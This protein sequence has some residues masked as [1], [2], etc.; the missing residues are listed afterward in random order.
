MISLISLRRFNEE[1]K[2]LYIFKNDNIIIIK[3]TDKSFGVV[4]WN[5]ED[6]LKEEHKQLSNKEV[7]E[8]VADDPST[9][10]STIFTALNK[11]RAKSDLSTKNS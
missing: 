8:K 2:A 10:E 1:R 7:Y 6:Y 4:V 11:I 3:G 5:R 9:L